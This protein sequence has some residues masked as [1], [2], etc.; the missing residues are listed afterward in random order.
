MN[1]VLKQYREERLRRCM[2]YLILGGSIP[3]ARKLAKMDRWG[4]NASVWLSALS[5]L[6]KRKGVRQ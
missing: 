5:Q 2:D 3:A 1:Q 6:L 4:A